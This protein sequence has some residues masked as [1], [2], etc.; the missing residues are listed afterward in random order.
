M[1]AGKLGLWFA[2]AVVALASTARAADDADSPVAPPAV[3]A[4]QAEPESAP[5]VSVENRRDPALMPYRRGYEMIRRIRDA[6]GQ[7]VQL[8]FRLVSAKDD[9]PVPDL[10][11]TIEG[12]RVFGQVSVDKDGYFTVPL[13]E[14]AYADGADFVTNQK[15]GSLKFGLTLEPQLAG[16][17]LSV[18]MLSD[19]VTRARRVIHEVV[20]WYLR[21]LLPRVRGAGFCYLQP[22]HLVRLGPDRDARKADAAETD[23]FGQ[24]VWCAFFRDGDTS[25]PADLLLDPDPGWQARYTASYF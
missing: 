23:R 15:R 1:P 22:G 16:D 25:L 9:K 10:R 19:S 18:D 8:Y 4:P 12:S 11:I 5:G 21:W 17:S 14:A 20:P 7:R 24:P 6:A 3:A 13:D 2:F